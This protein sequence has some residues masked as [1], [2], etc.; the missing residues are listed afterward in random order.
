M[1]HGQHKSSQ[2]KSLQQ[3]MYTITE[4]GIKNPLNQSVNTDSDTVNVILIHSHWCNNVKLD[5]N[6]LLILYTISITKV[7]HVITDMHSIL[8]LIIKSKLIT[9]IKDH[10]Y[11]KYSPW[12]SRQFHGLCNQTHKITQHAQKLEKDQ[13][14]V[15]CGFTF[16]FS[17]N[18]NTNRLTQ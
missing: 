15:L 16:N 7:S 1:Y 17:S 14:N 11:T 3:M 18:T 10:I 13:I 9:Y 8:L 6:L 2:W 12:L 4:L 5:Y